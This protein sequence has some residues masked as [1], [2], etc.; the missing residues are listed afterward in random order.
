MLEQ[1]LADFPPQSAGI[2]GD[3][4]SD[5][6]LER[7]RSHM[8]E[9]R[10]KH[11]DTITS[12]AHRLGHAFGRSDKHRREMHVCP[13]RLPSG[14]DHSDWIQYRTTLHYLN[15]TTLTLPFG[16]GDGKVANW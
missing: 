15:A 14:P 11:I 6:N 9:V 12:E 16:S 2:S 8:D 10:D 4:H 1:N 3:P 5:I 13:R 7:L